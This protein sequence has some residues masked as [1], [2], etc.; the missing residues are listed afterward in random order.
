MAHVLASVD[1]DQQ[2][3]RWFWNPG[4][5]F[6]VVAALTDGLTAGW[7]VVRNEDPSGEVSTLVFPVDDVPGLPTFV[8]CEKTGMVEVATLCDDVWEVGQVHSHCPKAVAAIIG[9]SITALP[10]SA[11][12]V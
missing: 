7:E 4:L 12:L 8:L 3:S 11:C 10:C 1:V 9:A 5:P 6:D 2:A